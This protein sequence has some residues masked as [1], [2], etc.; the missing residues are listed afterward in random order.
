MRKKQEIP[1]Q[2]LDLFPKNISGVGSWQVANNIF[3]NC[4]IE[5]HVGIPVANAI[6]W[7]LAV[8]KNI[9]W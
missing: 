6:L 7:V 1:S 2:F 5:E 4:F 3:I 9:K 8:C